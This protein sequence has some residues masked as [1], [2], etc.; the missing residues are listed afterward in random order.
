MIVSSAVVSH[1]YSMVKQ[2]FSLSFF[3]SSTKNRFER[4]SFRS[5][6]RVIEYFYFISAKPV[7]SFVKTKG[8]VRCKWHFRVISDLSAFLCF[9][10]HW[11]LA[12]NFFCITYTVIV[13]I[14]YLLTSIEKSDK[15]PIEID[16]S[17]PCGIYIFIEPNL[18]LAV[19]ENIGGGTEVDFPH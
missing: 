6:L 5:V 1:T 15:N 7:P 2:E 4:F 12:I 11:F 16:T 3:T 9:F 14:S 13:L 10:S 17:I 18:S 8:Q 19:D